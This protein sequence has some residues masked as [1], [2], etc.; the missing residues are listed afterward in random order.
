MTARFTPDDDR[1]AELGRRGALARWGRRLTPDEV[2]AVLSGLDSP[3]RIRAAVEEILKWTACG[4]L[5]A[6]AASAA[7]RGCEIALR[8]LDHTLDRQRI[9]SLERRIAELEQER[10][11]FRE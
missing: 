1:A 8:V 6:G 5:T 7:V 10:H 4:A 3:E 2:A 11:E 9:K